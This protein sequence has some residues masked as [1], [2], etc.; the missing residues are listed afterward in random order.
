MVPSRRLINFD[1]SCGRMAKDDWLKAALIIGGLALLAKVWEESKKN[2]NKV[3]QCWRCNQ[4][5]SKN[6]PSCPNCNAPQDWKG[7]E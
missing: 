5:I 7:V 1:T 2:N 4:I 6:T 3:Y